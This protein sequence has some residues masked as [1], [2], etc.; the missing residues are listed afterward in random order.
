[1]LRDETH[2]ALDDLERMEPRDYFPDANL[3]PEEYFVRTEATSRTR[4]AFSRSSMPA[5]TPTSWTPT[6]WRAGCSSID[7]PRRGQEPARRLRVQVEPGANARQGG[8]AD[9]SATRRRRA[10][11]RRHA[12]VPVRGSGRPGGRQRDADRSES[13]RVRAVVPGVA[14]INEN[15]H[16]WVDTISEHLPFADDGV[17]R[18]PSAPERTPAFDGCFGTSMRGAISRT[19][20]L[21][22][23]EATSAI[24]GC[25]SETSSRTTSSLP[26]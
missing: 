26:G 11:Q 18:L 6:T 1:M 19:S 14:G 20:H 17:E 3:A 25:R 8:L 15:V 24:K 22:R 4:S 12:A 5:Q 7:R 9:K 23:S 13:A 16:K 10:P 21:R 2:E